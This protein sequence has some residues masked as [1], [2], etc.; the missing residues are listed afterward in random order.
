M[1]LELNEDAGL[2]FFV[3]TCS[4]AHGSESIFDMARAAASADWTVGGGVG[5]RAE[6]YFKFRMVLAQAG[7]TS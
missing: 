7:R 4:S 6:K 5:V 3:R 1:H 2:R